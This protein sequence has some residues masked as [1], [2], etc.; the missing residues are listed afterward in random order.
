[1]PTHTEK[2]RRIKM[3]SQDGQVGGYQSTESSAG[4]TTALEAVVQRMGLEVSNW[5]K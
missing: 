2:L 1:M 5:K 4:E 3:R